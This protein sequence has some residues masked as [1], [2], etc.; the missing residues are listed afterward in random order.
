MVICEELGVDGSVAILALQIGQY[1]LVF[2]HLSK[3]VLWKIWPQ[4]I[5]C[6]E[7]VGEIL[8][9]QALQ[10]ICLSSPLETGVLSPALVAIV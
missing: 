8:S 5:F 2:T 9:L 4:A 6:P 1:G 3:Q 10:D 7:E